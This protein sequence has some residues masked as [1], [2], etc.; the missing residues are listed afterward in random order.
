MTDNDICDI[1]FS[2]R[3]YN[4]LLYAGIYSVESL[5]ALDSLDILMKRRYFGIASRNEVIQKMRECGYVKWADKMNV[6]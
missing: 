3:V 1:G 2:S 5:L 4:H 6:K